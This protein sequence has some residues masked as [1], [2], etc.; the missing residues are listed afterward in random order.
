MS[1]TITQDLYWSGNEN[2]V[3][4]FAD[5]ANGGVTCLELEWGVR[6]NFRLSRISPPDYS[7]VTLILISR[8]PSMV[9]LGHDVV[10]QRGE[11]HTTGFIR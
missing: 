9:I 6:R 5:V 2:H 7:I 11:G 1:L 3:H 10:V 4:H 8:I